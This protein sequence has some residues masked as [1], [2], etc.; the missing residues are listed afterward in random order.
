[1]REWCVWTIRCGARVKRA[2]PATTRQRWERSQ[3][4]RCYLLCERTRNRLLI[5]P[6]LELVT[7]RWK[8]LIAKN[9]VGSMRCPESSFDQQRF[10]VGI[11]AAERSI[12][13]VGIDRAA[14]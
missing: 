12:H 11:A 14:L 5:E 8:I 4:S 13:H 7:R 3:A 9:Q 10:H 1:M 6:T 2:S